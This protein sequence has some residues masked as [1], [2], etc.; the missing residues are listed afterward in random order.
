[1]L[2]V[3]LCCENGAQEVSYTP[4]PAKFFNQ[5]PDYPAS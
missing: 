3:V 4:Y 1:M 2:P 5:Y